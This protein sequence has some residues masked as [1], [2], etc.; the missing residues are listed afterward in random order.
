MIKKFLPL[1]LAAAML[2]GTPVV[3]QA[4]TVPLPVLTGNVAVMLAGDSTAGGMGASCQDGTSFGDRWAFGEWLKVNSGFQFTLVGSQS[5]T[6]HQPYQR[7]EGH[8]GFT[9]RQL[10]DNIGGY[11][12]NNP[13]QILIL[14]VGVNDANQGRTAAQM[15]AD[16]RDLIDNA[17]TAIP[18]VR[19]V[20][21]EIMGPNGSV[22]QQFADASVTAKEFNEALP[23]LTAPYG[24]AVR[25]AHLGWCTGNC[26][27]DGLHENVVGYL[28]AAAADIDAMWQGWCSLRP[29][30]VTDAGAMYFNVFHH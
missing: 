23:A 27:G 7:H 16:Y 4:S 6:C 20:A 28:F 1:V 10:A 29:Y 12:A 11:L 18:A 9:I 5:A 8:G 22:S 15:A 19:I 14:R 24:D 21:S 30:A 2:L 3:S 17:R 26:L 25:I 13:A